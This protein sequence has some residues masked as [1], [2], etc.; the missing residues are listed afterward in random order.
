MA[1]YFNKRDSFGR[2]N[3]FD[4]KLVSYQYNPEPLNVP[5][6]LIISLD[7]SENNTIFTDGVPTASQSRYTVDTSMIPQFGYKIYTWNVVG[8]TVL[9]GG[10]AYHDFVEV[11]TISDQAEVSFTITCTVSDTK[12]TATISKTFTHYRQLETRYFDLSG[13]V[14]VNEFGEPWT[15]V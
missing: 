13:E 8:A 1:G 14:W 2:H 4:N 5:V 11:G 3:P 9:S 10:K 15:T 12:K 6:D 7:E